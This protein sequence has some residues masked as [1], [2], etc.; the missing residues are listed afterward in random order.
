MILNIA[1]ADIC[2]AP[3]F[4]DFGRDEFGQSVIGDVLSVCVTFP[5]GTRYMHGR[6]FA[7][8]VPYIDEEEFLPGFRSTRNEAEAAVR[9]LMA[10][11]EAAG[12]IDTAHWVEVDPVYG[13]EAYVAGGYERDRAEAERNAA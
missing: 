10:K 1:N 5:D 12:K 11:I 3:E 7:T 4:C 6:R 8:I 9:A 2:I 13:S